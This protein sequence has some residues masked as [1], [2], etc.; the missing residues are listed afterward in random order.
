M[1]DQIIPD[2]VITNKIYVIRGQKVMLD[3]DLAQLYGTETKKLKQQVKRNMNRFPAHYMFELSNEENEILRSQNVTL[4]HGEHSK[5][6]PYVFTEHGI[7]MLSNVL[8]SEYAVA[9][10]IRIIDIFV[11]LRETFADQTEIWLQIERIKGKLD[12]QDKSMEI[13]FRYLDELSD[14]IPKQPEISPRKRIGYKP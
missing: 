3:R 9:V 7:L 11:K 14:R 13:V 12:N 2:E 6:L 4:R 1:K 5:Y 10:S 8:K